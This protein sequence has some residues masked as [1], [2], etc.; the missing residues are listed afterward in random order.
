[1][2]E[3]ND[4]TRDFDAKLCSSSPSPQDMAEEL[5]FGFLHWDN[6]FVD[7]WKHFEL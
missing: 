4:A 5:A 7:Q 1:M 3:Q 6:G 2:H